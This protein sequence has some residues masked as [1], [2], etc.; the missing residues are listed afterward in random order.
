MSISRRSASLFLAS[1]PLADLAFSQTAADYPSKAIKLVVPYPAG[2]LTDNIA[3]LFAQKVEAGLGRSMIIDNKPGA[4]SVLG[5]DQV[6]K[7][8]GDGYTLLFNMTALVQNPILLPRMPYVALRDFTPIIRIYELTAIWVTPSIIPVS[9]FAEFVAHA[10]DSKTPLSYGTTGHGSSSHFFAEIFSRATGIKM[11]HVPYKGENQLIPDLIAG[12]LDGAFISALAAQQY[13]K[14]GKLRMLATSGPRRLIALPQL[15]TFD[16]L[17]IPGMATP[18]FAGFF[19]PSSTPKPIVDKLNRELGKVL[20]EREM[21]DRLISYG[22][23]PAPPASAAEFMAVVGQAE[24]GW[25][26][27]AK[28]SDIKIE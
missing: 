10:K 26:A 4:N 28:T 8:P 16:D 27:I 5:T 1:L 18:S 3:R 17:G 12:R 21:I 15:P 9:T 20:G 6:A 23:D 7:S 13:A 19:A 24:D 2:G 22:V 11:S 14:E 25:R